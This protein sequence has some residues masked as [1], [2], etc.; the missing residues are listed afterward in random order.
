MTSIPFTEEQSSLP[1]TG[2]RRNGK[3]QACEP[4]RKGKLRC[5]HKYPFCGRCTRLGVTQ[6]CIYHPAP[7]TNSRKLDDRKSPA[8]E[9]RTTTHTQKMGFPASSTTSRYQ[10][11]ATQTTTSDD[12]QVKTSSK[13]TKGSE[14]S[15]GTWKSQANWKNGVYPR[16][17]RYYGPTSF[18][19]VFS[20][21]FLFLGDDL[22]KHPGTWVFGQPLLGR[23]R[24][25]TP[26]IRR[27][28]VLKALRNLPSRGSCERL[29][30]SFKSMHDPTLDRTMLSHFISA[31]W[32]EFNDELCLRTPESL[33]KISDTLFDNEETPLP[34]SPDDGVEW[35]N[36]FNGSKIRFE[37]LGVFFCFLG[38][39]YHFLQDCDP[40]LI[41]PENGGRDR[42]QMTWRMKECAD[43]CLNMCEAAE[44]VNYLVTSLIFNLKVLESG[45]TGDQSKPSI[46][47]F[48][49]TT[50]VTDVVLAYKIR[51]L[52]GDSKSNFEIST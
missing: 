52:N 46:H 35:L 5:D 9:K 14:D 51:R 4:C 29:A 43:V 39:A 36:T 44:T 10:H 17:S 25:N 32:S 20:E 21:E 31:L 47:L 30:S 41:E 49:I 27:S 45:C 33:T 8:R 22:R 23:E 50:A 38:L 18:Q 2:L 12:V 24:P 11:A 7:M 15:S 6:K 28:H 48:V 3:K 16:S 34:P 40:L 37:M 13:S 19:A 26:S 1:E 42:R